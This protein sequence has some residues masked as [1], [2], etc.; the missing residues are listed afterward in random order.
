MNDG[1]SE[2]RLRVPQTWEDPNPD[3]HRHPQG[4]ILLT[5]PALPRALSPGG[6]PWPTH[7]ALAQP[8]PPSPVKHIL[9]SLHFPRSPGTCLAHCGCSKPSEPKPSRLSV[10]RSYAFNF[11]PFPVPGPR[12]GTQTSWHSQPRP[13][14]SHRRIQTPLREKG[15][16][17][18]IYQAV[19]MGQT[20]C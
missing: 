1:T 5:G 6:A 12:P 11:E 3:M 13:R 20:L 7:P 10:P 16:I 14:T 4:Q 8:G 17:A 15:T 2:W 18:L 9:D 19:T